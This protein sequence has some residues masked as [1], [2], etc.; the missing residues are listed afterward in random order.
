MQTLPFREVAMDQEH[1]EVEPEIPENTTKRMKQKKNDVMYRSN[2]TINKNLQLFLENWE[3]DLLNPK[4]VKRY[5]QNITREEQTALKEI[6]NWNEQAVRIQDKG[7]RFVI[8]DSSDYRNS[9]EKP[10][11]NSCQKYEKK[12]NNWMGKWYSR[13][14]KIKKFCGGRMVQLILGNFKTNG[15]SSIYCEIFFE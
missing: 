12:V 10:L 4:N 11:E 14:V 6:R 5:W 3:K 8:L 15:N 2:P 7:S 9:F 1:E 13:P